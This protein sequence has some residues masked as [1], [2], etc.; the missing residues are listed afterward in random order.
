MQKKTAYLVAVVMFFALGAPAAE[1]S[2]DKSGK[3][4]TPIEWSLENPTFKGN[5]YDLI[6]TATFVHTKSGKKHTT[7][8]FYAGKGKTWKF[9]FT[10]TRTGKWTFT[11][12]SGD[13]DLAGKSGWVIVKPN[14]DP[15]IKGFLTT[16]GGKFAR[17][18]GDSG[19]LEAVRFNVYMNGGMGFRVHKKD[20]LKNLDAYLRDTKQYGFDTIFV[21]VA[22]SWF[23][24]GTLSYR[25]HKSKNPDPATFERLEKLIMTLHSQGFHLHIWAWGDEQRKW[26]PIG[27]GGINGI[28][29][30][31]LQR[32]IAARLGP[33][34]GWSMGYGFDLQE[35]VSEKQVGEWAAYMHR[36]LGWRHLLCARG[37]THKELDVISYS[38]SGPKTYRDVVKVMNKDVK[39]PHFYEERF[40]YKR[41]N[42]YDMRTTRRHLW[43]Y[44]MAGGMGSWWGFFGKGGNVY[45]PEK[46]KYPN[47]EQLLTCARFWNDRFLLDMAREN[48]LS[49]GYCLKTKSNTRFVFYKEDAVSI[50]MDLSKMTGV[51]KAVAVDTL[52]PY[53]EI[54]LG[55]LKGENQTWKAP[56]KSDWAIAVGEF[57]KK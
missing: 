11:T 56:Y 45:D 5:P 20:G 43:W 18:V 8:M 51:Q 9:R 27:V 31:R 52:K 39:R 35:W 47:P 2:M 40:T 1:K 48:K 28:P 41:W 23:K 29:D 7:G 21:I 13:P 25:Q 57:G 50:K 30:K 44:T 49:D 4:W 38:H 33:L 22:N 14:S 6:A 46:F 54:P 10:G 42:K 12:A 37:R 17:Q 36:H 53:K 3:M 15:K 34:P 55:K 16:R 32:Y 19:K 24:S 26:T